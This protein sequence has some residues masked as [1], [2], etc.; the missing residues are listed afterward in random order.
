MFFVY[1]FCLV[2]NVQVEMP[3][4]F[5][6]DAFFF[7]FDDDFEVRARAIGIDIVGLLMWVST[8]G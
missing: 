4:L 2:F 1:A 5:V 6:F 8:E 7:V 3:S